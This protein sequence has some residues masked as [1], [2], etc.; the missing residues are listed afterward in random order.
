MKRKRTT[1]VGVSG[2]AAEVRKFA[3]RLPDGQEFI[4]ERK[5]PIFRTVRGPIG[6]NWPGKGPDDPPK[7]AVVAIHRL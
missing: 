1:R 6:S 7:P 2:H 3:I 5:V 4:Q